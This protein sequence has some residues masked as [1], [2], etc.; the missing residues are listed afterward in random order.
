MGTVATA[1]R[2]YGAEK[3]DVGPWPPSITQLGFVAG[4]LT[5]TYFPAGAI[6][7]T[8]AYDSTATPSLTFLV[9]GTHATLDPAT[10]TLD[11]TGAWV[12]TAK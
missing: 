3:G 4:D 8:A 5:G 1:L 10:I 9:T 7:W 11:H 6:T 2:A 12:E